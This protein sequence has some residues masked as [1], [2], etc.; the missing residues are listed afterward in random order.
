[1]ADAR[2]GIRDTLLSAYRLINREEA[3]RAARSL[4]LDDLMR[5]EVEKA[6]ARI[7]EVSR[8]SNQVQ[9]LAEGLKVADDAPFV[10]PDDNVFTDV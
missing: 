8:T 10:D 3:L 2:A 7:A 5:A 1:M 4:D 9:V 6:P